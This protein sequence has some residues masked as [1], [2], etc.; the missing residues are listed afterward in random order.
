MLK[1][2]DLK[3]KML[4]FIGS[5]AL[6]AFAVTIFL[7]TTQASKLIK[8][9]AMKNAE[10]LGHR[11]ANEISKELDTAMNAARTTA[12]LFEGLKKNPQTPQREALNNMLKQLLELNPGFLGVWTCWETD[13]LDGR[14]AEFANAD[15]AHDATGE[16][17][18]RR[19]GTQ[20][21]DQERCWTNMVRS[22]AANHSSA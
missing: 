6:T 22:R 14:D 7:I 18:R 20:V 19:I 2:L 9:E 8:A 10:Q 4:L 17:D 15:A 12:H 1:R 5:V 13:A 16:R 21:A 11:Y 3:N